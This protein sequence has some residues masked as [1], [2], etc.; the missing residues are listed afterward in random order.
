LELGARSRGQGAWSRG[1]GDRRRE[2]SMEHGAREMEIDD[3]RREAGKRWRK[4]ENIFN[5]LIFNVLNLIS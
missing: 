3:R 2:I 4:R 1:N 5:Y